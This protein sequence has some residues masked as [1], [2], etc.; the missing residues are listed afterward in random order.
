MPNSSHVYMIE[1]PLEQLMSRASLPSAV[2]LSRRDL[3]AFEPCVE[4]GE[5]EAALSE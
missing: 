1:A 2:R 3:D 4:L 5:R